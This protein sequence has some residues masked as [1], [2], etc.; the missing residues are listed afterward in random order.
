LLER[1]RMSGGEFRRPLGGGI[2]RAD[3]VERTR[4][5]EYAGA[6]APL[7]PIARAARSFGFLNAVT[8]SDGVIRRA[9]LAIQV[10]G[11]IYPSLDAMLVA[12]VLGV[13]ASRIV[14]VAADDGSTGGAFLSSVDF[15]GRLSVPTD[16]RGLMPIDYHGGDGTFRNVSVA[17]VLDG[18]ARAEDLR[19]AVVLVGT[20]A[21]GTF[22]QRVTPFSRM[23]SG[24]E[25]HANA[26]ETM[27][28]RKFLRRGLVVETLELGA[29]VVLALGLAFVFARVPVGMALPTVL[30][31]CGAVWIAGTALFRAGYDVIVG[32]PLLLTGSMFVLVTVYRY[33]TEERDKRKLRSAF[34]LYLNPEVMEEMVRHPERLQLGGE[35]RELS[36]LF[37]DIRGFTSISEKLSPKALVHLLNEYLSPMTEIVFDKRGTLDKYIGDA[38]MAFFGA[39]V[40]NEHHALH[41]C[42][43]ALEMVEALQRLQA[44]WR[45]QGAKMPDIEIGIGINS[46]PMVVGNMG[47]TQ[48]FNYTV[49]GDN[50]NLASRLEGLN[51]EYGTRILVTES[52]VSAALRSAGPG[53]L[54]VREID[55]V[56]V[57]GRH[58]A[59]IIF[60]LR[61]RGAATAKD[62][63]LL[64]GYARGL[65]LYRRRR[66]AEARFEFENVAARFPDDGPSRAML[67]RCDELTAQPPPAEW[68]GAFQMQRK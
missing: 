55:S 40:P 1:A 19:G 62:L 12:T 59:V 35:E 5:K 60:E 28:S 21:Q 6:R 16:S 64:D 45:M 44:R 9:A 56:R 54:A 14:P 15:G 46:G 42:E 48:R 36:V 8:D 23:T 20:T 29:L 50:V 53:A 10:R 3:P 67:V 51:K 43:A 37:S 2:E 58:E 63:P 4:L 47:S 39:P 65:S 33:A 22:D 7:V 66:F 34:Q 13:P 25:T 27:L 41:C 61:G 11:R 52:V 32:L 26:I 57:K 30:L 49:I 38:L 68:Q 24:V 17:D 18:R 31:A